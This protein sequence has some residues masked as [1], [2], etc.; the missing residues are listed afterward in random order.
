MTTAPA[1]PAPPYCPNPGCPFHTAPEGWRF[2]RDGYHS[3]KAPPHRVQRFRCCHCRRRFSEQTFRTTYWLKR[4]ELLEPTFHGLVSCSAL[5]QIARAQR[6][7]PQTIL[8]HANRLGRHCLLFH[9]Q[10]RPRDGIH[11]SVAMDGF[12]SFEYSQYHPTSYNLLAGRRSYFLYAFTASELRRSGTMTPEQRERRATLEAA[13]GRPHPRSVEH[14]CVELL[15]IACPLPQQLRLWTDEHKA[16]PRA[17]ARSTHLEVDHHTISSKAK[18]TARNPL[19]SVNLAD[20][21]LRHTGA[22]H[23]RE[24]IAFSKRRW[25]AILR[26]F[27]LLVWRNYMKSFSERAKD[28][29]PAMRLGLLDRRL[30]VEEVLA[31]RLFP[32]RVPLPECWAKYYWGKVPT[33]AVPNGRGHSLRYAA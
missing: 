4:P 6:A 28:G 10:L 27:V 19:F 5:R 23:K 29:S 2:Q 25:F 22:N 14:D 13:H 15:R 32:G 12:I 30:T 1:S 9:Q 26:M 17:I 33:R 31:Q 21:M 11:E 24:T 3:R 8:L 7:S 20:G 18:R 16:Y